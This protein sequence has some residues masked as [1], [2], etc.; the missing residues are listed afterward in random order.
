MSDQP[1]IFFDGVCGLCNRAVD[2]LIR[3]DKKRMFLFAPLQG[4]TAKGELPE[5][6]LAKTD[7]IILKGKEQIYIKSTAIL[8][9]FKRIGG[10]WRF[11]ALFYVFPKIFRDW[12]YDI[13]AN[14]RYKVFGKKESCRIPSPE[15]REVFLD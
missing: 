10:V 13:V 14:N 11:T 3:R 1:I 4:A 8:E 6:L 15:E 5:H 2:F 12:L 7:T 9:I